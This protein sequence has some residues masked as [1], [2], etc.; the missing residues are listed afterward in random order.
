MNGRTLARRVACVAPLLTAAFRAPAPA[1]AQCVD[2]GQI[3]GAWALQVDSQDTGTLGDLVPMG[4][5]ATSDGDVFVVGGFRGLVD[6]DPSPTGADLR[7]SIMSF[8]NLADN[9]WDL[10]VTRL[11]ADGSYGGTYVDGF[12]WA[13]AAT[14]VAVDPPDELDPGCYVIV[15]GY[16]RDFLAAGA[17][18]S[19]GRDIF[20]AK[21]LAD[22][23]FG[24]S[25][26]PL[27][28]RTISN[29]DAAPAGC[30]ASTPTCGDWP[31]GL[32]FD[33]I[34]NVTFCLPNAGEIAKFDPDGFDC[35]GCEYP[36]PSTLSLLSWVDASD[37]QILAGVLD[38]PNLGLCPRTLADGG[39]GLMTLQAIAIDAVGEQVYWADSAARKIQ[40]A[41]LPNLRGDLSYQP[42]IATLV[43]GS[44]NLGTPAALAL[45]AVGGKLYWSDIQQSGLRGI[46][47]VNVDG[48][49]HEI[50]VGPAL[51][52]SPRGIALDL[53]A[54][55][56][57]WTESTTHKIKRANLN[58]GGVEDVL[59]GLSFPYGLAIDA[60][61][62]RLFWSSV[63]TGQVRRANLDGSE[64]QTIVSNQPNP[65][66]VTLDPVE[67]KV[68]WSDTID[69]VI[70]RADLDGSNVEDYLT[71]RPEVA[72]MA[73]ALPAP[74]LV[75]GDCDG[76]GLVEFAD[77]PCLV[78]ALIGV[79]T[80]PPGGIARSDVNEDG[81]SNGAD[82][83][84]F[85]ELLLP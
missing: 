63:G 35:P 1:L 49:N 76:N 16:F 80:N 47:R 14:L 17:G 72:G 8:D 2:A 30:F 68:Y 45:D 67:G 5:A 79:D 15:A 84:F 59:T 52:Q 74:E 51:A 24:E 55:K 26:F 33:P 57:Y 42:Q 44:L 21:F 41:N 29:N 37:L 18:P 69:D 46:H 22:V 48:S 62:G 61:G 19:E 43:S 7:E 32:G 78:D 40:R 54:S 6:F 25:S 4:Y 9:E 34:D 20:V 56:V 70:R 27:W 77:T 13:D 39:D 65:L 12:W 82:V 60:A 53:T 83:Q 85:V 31:L 81:L 11:N 64:I 10:F 58:G 50:V 36:P 73:I 38:P 23:S 66:A 75:P 3:G 71:D 28:I